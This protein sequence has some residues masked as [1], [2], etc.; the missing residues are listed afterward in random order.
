MN[1]KRGDICSKIFRVTD[2]K[3]AGLDK[4]VIDPDGI[5]RYVIVQDYV[6]SLTAHV[7][8]PHVSN[9]QNDPQ[10]VSTNFS[11]A[12]VY[13]YL[14]KRKAVVLRSLDSDTENDSYELPIAEK[15]L[16]KGY[17]FYGSGHI[18][19]I[20][21]NRTGDH[22]HLW[23]RVQSS[24]K[25]KVYTTKIVF[26]NTGIILR[27]HCQCVAGKGGKC[28]HV[29]ASLFAVLDYLESQKSASCTGQPQKWHLPSRKRK[30]Q[31]VPTKIGERQVTKHIFG[32][33][34]R[35]KSPLE[36]YQDYQAIA[37]DQINLDMDGMKSDLD[38]FGH[39]T[40]LHQILETSPSEESEEEE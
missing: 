3:E 29:A 33:K 10:S 22:C 35:T 2:I 12:H 13:E 31:T 20:K 16:R 4:F 32:R 37:D 21:S 11:Y 36:G 6:D 26:G 8:L 27:G 23:T 34:K 9:W 30:R 5:L 39:L 18:E 40:C 38:T 14:V 25:D 24:M 17:N 7:T 1:Q 28:N 15:P 19:E